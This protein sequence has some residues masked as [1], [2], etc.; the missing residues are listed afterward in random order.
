ME[1]CRRG[2]HSVV[3]LRGFFTAVSAVPY[4]GGFGIIGGCVAVGDR[5][6]F[7][8]HG[9]GYCREVIP[10]VLLRKLCLRLFLLVYV[11]F[12]C[13]SLLRIVNGAQLPEDQGQ[14]PALSPVA[15]L[16][17]FHLAEGY[18]LR[19]LLTEPQISQPLSTAYDA[20]GRLWVVQ[21]LQ[22]P[23]PA[24]LR[25]LSRDNFWRTVYDRVPLP[26]GHGGVKGA[27]KITVHEDLDGDGTLETE[28]TFI[29]GLNIA[30]SVVPTEDGAWVLNPPYLLFYSDKDRDLKADGPPD[31]HLEGFGLEDTHSVVNSLCMGPDGWLYAAQ[32]STVSGNVRRYGSN[33]S[34]KRSMG[35]SIWR[36]HPI[37][38]Q[39]EIFAEGGGN[40]FS[41][42]F[43]DN[44]E[45]FSGHNG[46]DTRGFHY[47]Q[48][49]YYRKGFNKHGGLSNPNTFGYLDPMKHLPI[50]RFTHA[51]MMTNGTAFATSMPDSMLAVDPLHGKL[52]Q[53][54]LE[55]IGSTFATRDIDD[56]VSSSDKWFRPVA[57]QDSP[58]GSAVVCD[59]YDFQVA[60]LYAHVGKMDRDHGRIYELRPENASVPRKWN[61]RLATGKSNASL[62]YLHECLHHPY[63]WQRWKARQLLALHPQR[64][65]LFKTIQG[66]IQSPDAAALDAL[67]AAHA[68]GWIEDTIPFAGKQSIPLSMLLNHQNSMIRAWAVR[69]ACDDRTLTPE[70][71]AAIES[72]ARKEKDP[73]VLCQLA[74]SAK[75]LQGETGLAIVSALLSRRLPERDLSLPLMIWWA[76]EPHANQPAL[77]LKTLKREPLFWESEMVSTRILPNLIELWVNANTPE[78]LAAISQ[79]L[80]EMKSLP[81]ENQ[82]THA[83][84]A[85]NAMERALVGRSWLG[86]SD[87]V[88]DALIALGQPSLPLRLRRGDQ[89]AKEEAIR[90]INDGKSSDS[91]RLSLMQLASELHLVD[92]LPSLMNAMANASNSEKIRASAISALAVFDDERVS[93]SILQSWDRLPSSLRA[94]AGSVLATRSGWTASWLDA[95]AIEQVDPTSMPM[96]CVR[97]MRLH[98]DEALQARISATY[99]GLAGPDL[100]QATKM[101]AEILERIAP[102]E[103]DPYRGKKLFRSDCARCHKLYAEGGEIGPD[104]TGYQRDQVQTLVRNII[105]PSL[106]IREGYQTVG[107]RMEDGAVLTGFIE[108]QKEEQFTLKGVDGKAH[109]VAR[110]EIDQVVP[111]ATSLMPEGMLAK[112]TDQQ[113][114]DL[115][116]YLRSSQPLSDG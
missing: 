99:P 114:A 34:S 1:G 24:G 19:T 105:A 12:F 10:T 74:S 95:V 69:L 109:V 22:Y 98:R 76:I 36:Y 15:A 81:N 115:L 48:E 20:Y 96:E 25:R 116:A 78:S 9:I 90:T 4:W 104:L 110:S 16:A 64:N 18:R 7:N 46:G 44:G 3:L 17:Q 79:L 6:P 56:I 14:G 89:A 41:V 30:T 113:I 77:V 57:I 85:M 102:L 75:R 53:T 87:H 62:E 70:S 28:T 107:V 27:D 59:W 31:V 38:H 65:A 52:I 51:M 73:K 72:L 63:R 92:A 61:P 58:D 43:D 40:A 86:I 112:L 94:V 49:A 13:T 97:A 60:H 11:F 47:L 101:V 45:I 2:A 5:V 32:G 84:Q 91:N 83:K 106:E 82:A 35:Q 67:W 93:P 100:P 71:S 21:Y 68:C 8:L 33:E 39:Y 55:P 88:L 29:D 50:Q 80:R 66:N 54:Q 103:G 108:N 26:P 23:E 37:T 111:Q 42:A